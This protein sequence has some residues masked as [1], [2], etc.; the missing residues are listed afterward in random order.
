MIVAISLVGAHF[1]FFQTLTIISILYLV[2]KG[3]IFIADPFS[4]LDIM[5]ALYLIL[6]LFGISTFIT[7]IFLLY[8]GYK[9]IISFTE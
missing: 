5:M 6:L 7:W 9:I 2:I 3:I 4:I 8:I 1:G